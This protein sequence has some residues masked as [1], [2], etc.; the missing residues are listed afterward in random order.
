LVQAL[1][2]LVRLLCFGGAVPLAT[3]SFNRDTLARQRGFI[4][5]RGCL[6]KCYP[7]GKW[8]THAAAMRQRVKSDV[9]ML[10]RGG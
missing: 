5:R 1:E 7:G 6:E 9:I 3:Q 4:S 10:G 8:I 2:S